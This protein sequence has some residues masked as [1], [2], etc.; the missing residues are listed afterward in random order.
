MM[1]KIGADVQELPDC[2]VRGPRARFAGPIH[3]R[4]CLPEV[5][6]LSMQVVSILKPVGSDAQ[7]LM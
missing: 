2:D 4:P 6:M 1:T 7:R 3:Q 5:V